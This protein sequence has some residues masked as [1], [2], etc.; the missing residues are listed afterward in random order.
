LIRFLHG[1]GLRVHRANPVPLSFSRVNAELKGAAEGSWKAGGSASSLLG[2]IF[3]QSFAQLFTA[4]DDARWQRVLTPEKL[5]DP[6]I[7]ARHIYQ[8]LVGPRILRQ[9][10]ALQEFSQDVLNFWEALQNMCA[11]FCKLLQSALDAG[12]VRF[13]ELSGYWVNADRL[14]RPEKD[15]HWIIQEDGWLAPV[16]L[17]GTAGAVF[18]KPG[19]EG[20]YV[21]EF[22]NGGT[23]PE[24]DLSQAVLYHGLLTASTG[25]T[26]DVTMLYFYPGLT[27]RTF[28]WD[29]L[30]PA[31]QL[32]KPTIG[33]VAGVIGSN[34]APELIGQSN[35]DRPRTGGSGGSLGLGDDP[36]PAPQDETGAKVL[37][38]CRE[39]GASD[40]SL[41][42]DPVDGPA[43]RRYS[44]AS[45]NREIASEK[46]RSDLAA[47]LQNQF[48]LETP[49]LITPRGVQIW[50]DVPKS[51][52]RVVSFDD[53]RDQM[54]HNLANSRVPVGV[55]MNSAIRWLDLTNPLHAHVLVAGMP[56]SGK[57]EWMRSAV[58]GLM[59]ANTPDTLRLVLLDSRKGAFRD[60]KG[61]P[62]LYMPE[63]LV[64]PDDG[65]PAFEVLDALVEEM[66]ARR[67]AHQRAFV[68]D[69]R[70][71]IDKTGERKPRIVCV[72]DEYTTLITA[73]RKVRK[74]VETRIAKLGARARAAGIH[75]V[76]ATDHPS[77]DVVAGTLQANLTCR[78]VLRV[79]SAIESRLLL[80]QAGAESLLGKG[81]LFFQ[82]IQDPLRLQGLLL[83]DAARK[84]LFSVPPPTGLAS[85]AS[86]ASSS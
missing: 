59:L 49:P 55:D 64:S 8:E 32:L 34:L 5:A 73:D 80:G 6:S 50:V 44:V 10:A 66:E 41:A 65:V 39:T 18:Q 13:D 42:G 70:Q 12:Q 82:D 1:L 54:H 84:H 29:Q 22:R 24:T 61:S 48:H 85:S 2:R 7:L 75:L 68:Q 77:R 72:C 25:G 83:S 76:L 9:Q 67:R 43:F 26:G 4:T 74:D 40:V 15:L 27:E 51:E 14:V 63:A 60:C 69:L 78:V 21:L 3:H 58:A 38:A 79:S 30:Q 71:Y 20:W 19:G 56:G 33:R 23:S 17:E 57:T 11:W 28:A 16:R 81:D 37:A 35:L 47:T 52:R 31:F 45:A 62:F 53:L 86:A 36:A 46:H